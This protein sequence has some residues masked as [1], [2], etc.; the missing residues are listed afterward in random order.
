MGIVGERTALPAVEAWRRVER[1]HG[2]ERREEPD[3]AG[4]LT[5]FHSKGNWLPHG[6]LLSERSRRRPAVIS[7]HQ[8]NRRRRPKEESHLEVIGNKSENFQKMSGLFLWK[9]LWAV[10]E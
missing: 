7:N 2:R 4:G 9:L 10:L 8:L 5:G 6:G 1:G 3:R